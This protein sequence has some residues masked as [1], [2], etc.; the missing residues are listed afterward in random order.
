MKELKLGRPI[1]GDQKKRA[2]Y[3]YRPMKGKP[4]NANCM[5][6]IAACIAVLSDKMNL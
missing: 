2:N 5:N 6:D 3:I 4:S 1:L